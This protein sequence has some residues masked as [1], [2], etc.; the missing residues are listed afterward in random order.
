MSQAG[1]W[2]SYSRAEPWS[3]AIKLEIAYADG[4]NVSTQVTRLRF[5]SCSCSFSSSSS[6]II[7]SSFSWKSQKILMA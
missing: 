3:G 4:F 6:F 7:A 5:T 1:L 2:R